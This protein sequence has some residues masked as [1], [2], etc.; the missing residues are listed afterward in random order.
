MIQRGGDYINQGSLT[1]CDSKD[2]VYVMLNHHDSLVKIRAIKELI[3]RDCSSFTPEIGRIAVTDMSI[4]V[5][6]CAVKALEKIGDERAQDYLL[7]ALY[8]SSTW[9]R[10]RAAKAL[11]EIGDREALHHL[12]RIVLSERG[13][14]RRNAAESLLKLNDRVFVEDRPYDIDDIDT[15]EYRFE[16]KVFNSLSVLRE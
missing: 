6:K 16:K 12:E 9:V 1:S 10:S 2:V 15:N 3:M 4:E 11:G 5:R 8:D 13:A 7:R 14:V